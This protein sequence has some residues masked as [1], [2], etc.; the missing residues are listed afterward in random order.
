MCIIHKRQKIQ[1]FNET[2]DLRYIY[3]NE[4]DKGCFLHDMA[5]W[6]FKDLRRR[7]EPDKVL[8]DKGFK[9]ASNPKYDRYQRGLTS[10]V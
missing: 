4:L 2:G 8:D 5:Y 1:T 7:A 3:R 10:V 6:D 9:I